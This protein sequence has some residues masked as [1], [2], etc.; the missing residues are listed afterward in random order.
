MIFVTK[1]IRTFCFVHANDFHHISV[2]RVEI[3]HQGRIRVIWLYNK[4]TDTMEYCES[5]E[6][7]LNFQTYTDNFACST[8]LPLFKDKIKLLKETSCIFSIF[9][10]NHHDTKISRVII[11]KKHWNTFKT[12]R[13][14][15][16]FKIFKLHVFQCIYDLR[17]SYAGMLSQIQLPKYLR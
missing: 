11:L 10:H 8:R 9:S 17:E 6:F 1:F 15:N 5:C 3:I 13:K 7:S 2:C 4:R 16:I 14:N 12:K